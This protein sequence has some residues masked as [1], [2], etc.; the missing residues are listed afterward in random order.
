[1][2]LPPFL[3]STS[4]IR[5]HVILGILCGIA[6]AAALVGLVQLWWSPMDVVM[7]YKCM[8]TIGLMGIM[9][10]FVAAI[11]IDMTGGRIRFLLLALTG[12]V[13]LAGILCLGQIWWQWI[14][15]SSFIKIMI[16]LLILAALDAFIMAAHEDFGTNKRLKDDK[17]ID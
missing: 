7:L 4:I 16:S 10:G 2:P 8:A 5:G 14:A 3:S 6:A 9:T 12:I 17:Y 1:M 13:L 11:N 15:P